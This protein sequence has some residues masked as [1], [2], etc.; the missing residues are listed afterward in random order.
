MNIYTL[1]RTLRFF[2]INFENLVK[3]L[4]KL[5]LSICSLLRKPYGRLDIMVNPSNDLMRLFATTSKSD[6]IKLTLLLQKSN[7]LINGTSVIF[8]SFLHCSMMGSNSQPLKFCIA[9]LMAL[10]EI[11]LIIILKVFRFILFVLTFSSYFAAEF[12]LLFSFTSFRNL[13]Y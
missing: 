7:Y 8:T 9:L 11:S 10:E 12:I 3:L 13:S 5:C 6:K 4:T 1:A 2:L